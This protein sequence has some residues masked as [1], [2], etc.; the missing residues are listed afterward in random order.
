MIKVED[1]R[2][3]YGDFVALDN[4]NFNVNKGEFF[5]LLGPSG[6][7]KSTMLRA[8]AGFIE[9][10]AGT[11]SID[12]RVV[13]N[14]PVED[15]GIG[16]VFQSYAL[17]PSMSVYNNIAFGLNVEGADKQ[18]IKE[19]VNELARM[20]DLSDDQLKKNVSELSGGQQQRVAITRALAKKPELL[21]MDEPL[22]NLDARL[23]KSL[24]QELKNI[25]HELGVTTL[26]VTHDQ[27]E[28][29]TLSN[30]IAVF[31]DGRLEQVG[32]PQEIYS[33][34]A[35]EFVCSFIGDS[36][37]LSSDIIKLI[38]PEQIKKE[39]S[40]VF[41][42]RPE[43]IKLR[44]HSDDHQSNEIVCTFKNK[45]YYGTHY[46][47]HILHEPTNTA[48]DVQ[49]NVNHDNEFVEGEEVIVSFDIQKIHAF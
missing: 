6:S 33:H 30:R 9:P 16:M 39:R 18:Y 40:N 43:N 21:A 4:I 29:L 5:T 49:E 31:S 28:A 10:S 24:R 20:V 15:R 7:G 45:D 12:G 3:N 46:V 47:Y 34:P 22:S 19:R 8:I 23:R 17:F 25:Q 27:E 36:N 26:Y 38:A 13:N 41:Y 35:S 42:V 48:I 1:V 2:I 44:P 37:K 32:T 11:I 14:T